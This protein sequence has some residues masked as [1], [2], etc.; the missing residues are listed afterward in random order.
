MFGSLKKKLGIEGVK[1]ELILIPNIVKSSRTVTGHIKLTS[2]SDDHLINSINIKLIEKYTRGRGNDRLI[3]EYTLGEITLN[4]KI[5]ISKNDMIE[6]P[7]TL[8][9][10]LGTSE[11]DKLADKNF[12]TKGIVSTLKK[13]SG[14][15]SSYSVIAEAA[16]EGTKLHPMDKKG[17]ELK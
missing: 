1:I 14:V 13:I 7:F 4:E 9:F 11:M 2:L 5:N 3:N 16:V 10:I 12:L 8:Q 17:V 6:I 15:H